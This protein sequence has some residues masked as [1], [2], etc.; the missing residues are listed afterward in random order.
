MRAS[1][2]M[3]EDPNFL[4]TDPEMRAEQDKAAVKIQANWKGKKDRK[5]VQKKK[6][7]KE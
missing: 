1:Q 7:E 6:L 2:K 4:A 5:M 3:Q